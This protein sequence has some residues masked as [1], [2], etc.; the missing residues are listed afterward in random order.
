MKARVEELA[1]AIAKGSRERL[2]SAWARAK[3][4]YEVLRVLYSK[5]AYPAL[6]QML[7]EHVEGDFPDFVQ[8]ETAFYRS[9][10]MASQNFPRLKLTDQ[11]V[12]TQT[13]KEFEGVLPAT[14]VMVAGLKKDFDTRHEAMAARH[15]DNIDKNKT[16]ICNDFLKHTYTSST[17][18]KMQELYRGP[19]ED[20]HEF[21]EACQ[22]LQGSLERL[23]KEMNTG[24]LLFKLTATNHSEALGSFPLV[25]RIVAPWNSLQAA[26][27]TQH[28]TFLERFYS[29]MVEK[30]PGAVP[31][32]PFVLKESLEQVVAL[33][34]AS[35]KESLEPLVSQFC[36]N[37][38]ERAAAGIQQIDMVIEHLRSAPELY[39]NAR[40]LIDDVRNRQKAHLTSLKSDSSTATDGKNLKAWLSNRAGLLRQLDALQRKGNMQAE[41]K[42]TSDAVILQIRGDFKARL[43]PVLDAYLWRNMKKDELE[44]AQSAV[45]AYQRILTELPAGTQD[46]AISEDDLKEVNERIQVKK[47]SFVVVN[48]ESKEPSE[49]ASIISDHLAMPT[50]YSDFERPHSRV[51]CAGLAG[52]AWRPCR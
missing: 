15:S 2:E 52:V 16:D 5:A 48:F 22:E 1:N 14:D 45:S 24:I 11:S 37:H 35:L 44:S 36:Q 18:R 42:A 21:A 4:V 38:L 19:G 31:P 46:L 34:V 49:Q 41:Y 28:S 13:L 50:E 6:F 33:M 51:P 17:Y 43:A 30:E 9:L 10:K 23:V 8:I 12:L 20:S 29:N 40:H 32:A 27:N 3:D 47:R 25:E 26:L 7:Y 39:E